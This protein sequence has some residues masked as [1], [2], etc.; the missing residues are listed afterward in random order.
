FLVDLAVLAR[1]LAVGEADVGGGAAA[2][3]VIV[4]ERVFADLAG[5]AFED[6][7]RAGGAHLARRGRNFLRAEAGRGRR[8]GLLRDDARAAG[9]FRRPRRVSLRGRP[10]RLRLG[11]PDGQ[12]ESLH[13]AGAGADLAR[14]RR[15]PPPSLRL[16]AQGQAG[17]HRTAGRGVGRVARRKRGGAVG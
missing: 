14:L 13:A 2:E 6:Q 5:R 9:G 12:A 10:G 4:A 11:L 15:A 3:D 1:D 16:R 17:P 8:P 7:P